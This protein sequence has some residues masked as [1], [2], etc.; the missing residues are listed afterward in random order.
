MMQTR[1]TPTGV[2][3]L[4]LTA[5]RIDAASAVHFKDEFREAVTSRSGRVIMDL[6]TVS[7]MDSSGLGAMV[8]ALKL[9]KGRDLEL[10]GLSPAVD[11]VFRLTRMEKVFSLHENLEQALACDSP[12][13]ADAA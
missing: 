5:N 8:A 13:G 3:V 4:T 9:L 10:C 6:S 12:K 2:L 11:K 7:F 1:E